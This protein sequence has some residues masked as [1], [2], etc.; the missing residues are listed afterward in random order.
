MLT[1][2]LWLKATCGCLSDMKC[3]HSYFSIHNIKQNFGMWVPTQWTMNATRNKSKEEG[4]LDFQQVQ[5]KIRFCVQKQ[6]AYLY[7]NYT[8]IVC[9]INVLLIVV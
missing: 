3:F 4:K 5:Q 6:D 8:C 9:S 1:Y 2:N 7:I